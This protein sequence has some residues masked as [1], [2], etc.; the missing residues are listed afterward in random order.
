M[1]AEPLAVSEDAVLGGRLV[2]RQPLRGHRVGH[3]AILLAAATPARAG[4]HA[5]ELGSGVGGA[6]LAL[7]RRVEGLAVTMVEIDPVLAELGRVNAEANGFAGRVRSVCLDVA[8]TAVAFVAAGLA[9]GSADAVLMNP[10]FND[11][12]NPSPEPGRRLARVAS[13]ETLPQ[14]LRTAARL[15]RPSGT[16]TLIWRGDGVADVIAALGAGFGAVSLIPIHAKPGAPA[17][18]VVARAIKGSRAPLV[19][20]P[21]LILADAG[22][23]PTAQA[24]AILREGAALS[25][26]EA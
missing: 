20:L 18:R 22:G 23:K 2:L 9:P 3:D 1:P 7:A 15:L 5:V 11:R 16:V 24:E 12:Q 17:V 14:W 10:P 21:G 26:V 8:A 19:L 25:L 4:E 13:P 6:G